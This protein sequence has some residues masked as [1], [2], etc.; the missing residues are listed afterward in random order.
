[1]KPSMLDTD[2]L[3]EFLRGNPTVVTKIDEH[4]KKYGSISFSIITYYEIMNGLLYK[5]ARKQLKRFNNFTKLSKVIP[6]TVRS[7]K[8][9]AELFADL[10]KKGKEIGHTAA[11]VHYLHSLTTLYNYI[12]Y[13][14]TSVMCY[15][16]IKW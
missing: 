4:L 7:A 5:D 13:L 2:I 9:S 16:L 14:T 1:M 10:R 12:D 6:L 3:S 8:K 15:N 11:S